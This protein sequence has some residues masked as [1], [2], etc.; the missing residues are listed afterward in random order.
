MAKQSKPKLP[1]T[2]AGVKVP[3]ALRKSG[4]LA[5]MVG[6]PTGRQ[7]VADALVA[8][9]AAAAAVLAKAALT[10]SDNR[11]SKYSDGNTGLAE[12]AHHAAGTISAI[13]TA[14]AAAL[15]APSGSDEAESEE[16]GRTPE[17]EPSSAQPTR[18]RTRAKTQKSTAAKREDASE[19]EAA[20]G[21]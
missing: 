10:P 11:R 1:K 15:H 18:R 21:A 14:A 5:T 7:L 17:P 8:A 6:S 4:V 12:A 2:V 3:K 13:L 19:A 20:D 16:A 9:G